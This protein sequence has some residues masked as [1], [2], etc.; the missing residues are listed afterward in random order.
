MKK[1]MIFTLIIASLSMSTELLPVST[2]TTET[3]TIV[4]EPKEVEQEN[5]LTIYKRP[6]FISK[7][8]D[9]FLEEEEE[10]KE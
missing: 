5:A 4:H 3:E 1:Y 9:Q 7:W 6:D 2:D 8:N 10:V